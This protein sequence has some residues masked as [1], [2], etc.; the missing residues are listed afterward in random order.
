MSVEVVSES[1]HR[2]VSRALQVLEAA[3]IADD[4]VTLAGLAI[5]LDAPKSSL[6][7]VVKA[8]VHRGYLD[9]R[10]ARYHL[11]PAVT[12]L[13]HVSQ[14]AVVLAAQDAMAELNHRFNETVM[15]GTMVGDTLVYLDVVE[16]SQAVRYSPPRVRQHFERPSSIMKLY[17]ADL[18][19]PAFDRYLTDRIHDPEFATRLRAEVD[20]A[21]THGIAYNRGD[22][23][24]DLSA[25]AARISSRD[26]LVAALS[27]GGPSTRVAPRFDELAAAVLAGATQ[28]S[29]RLSAA[30]GPGHGH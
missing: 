9:L 27:I 21:R 24:E 28:V 18:E 17:L 3:A 25:V 16:S 10:N 14:P 22:T 20:H 15:L 2:A 8:L 19:P 5:A 11:G 7:P 26:G 23:F 12:A 4:G 29:A 13:S 1:G 6:H 30:I